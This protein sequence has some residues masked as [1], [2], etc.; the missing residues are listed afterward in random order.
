MNIQLG[1]TPIFDFIVSDPATGAAAAA[2]S[3]PTVAVFEDASDTPILTPTAT[4]RSGY[5]GDYRVPVAATTANGFELGK[6]YN[7]VVTATVGGVVARGVVKT[8]I[9]V[10]PATYGAVQASG[11]NTATTFLTDRTES[12][13]D[14]FKDCLVCF[15]SGSLAG[16][17]KKVTSYN[18]TT[19]FLSFT[20]GFTGAPAT[21]DLF[22][23]INQ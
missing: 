17:V 8:F 18:G 1:S 13:T 4:A 12:T 14:H 5:T 15:L 21:G 3:T 22:V 7:V 16:Q 20:S 9:V 10:P 6:S 11:S 2:D 23:L 19:K